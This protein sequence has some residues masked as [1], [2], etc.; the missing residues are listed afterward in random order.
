MQTDQFYYDY[1]WLK[2]GVDYR[3]KN[4]VC[5]FVGTKVLDMLIVS[6]FLFYTCV[7][8]WVLDYSDFLKHL[9]VILQTKI[10]SFLP[11]F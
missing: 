9:V 3:E 6:E 8:Y 7:L 5:A 11:P 10:S 1:L 2:N 4:C